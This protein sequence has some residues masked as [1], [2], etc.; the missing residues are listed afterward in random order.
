MA[1]TLNK[2]AIAISYLL[3]VLLSFSPI[4]AI[5][6]EDQAIFD[7]ILEPVLRI[8]DFVKYAATVIAA[9]F[10]VFTA[11]TYMTSGSDPKKR[12]NAKFMIG[13]ILFGLVI[14]WA[15]PFI[16]NYLLQ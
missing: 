12:D 16:I 10:L 6:P 15:T 14:I 5:S 9:L 2:I 11:I 3:M 7:Q 8:Y 4:K 13:S 1:K